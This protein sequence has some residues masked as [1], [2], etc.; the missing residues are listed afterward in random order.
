MSV[1][2]VHAEDLGA[3]KASCQSRPSGSCDGRTSLSPM[4]SACPS[5]ENPKLP[6]HGTGTSAHG[7]TALAKGSSGS[8]T[9]VGAARTKPLKKPQAK[10]RAG[11]KA[12]KKLERLVS[13]GFELEPA[14]AT[15]F[16]ALSARANYLS[17]D[18]LDI[19]FAGKEFCREFAIP[20]TNSF[21]KL[22]KWSDTCA[23]YRA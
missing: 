15:M 5:A 21:L 13:K 2:V 6:A 3:A 9:I 23:A 20:N 8:S 16:C 18:R 22:N 7:S 1:G 12:T 10:K 17:Q 19:S 4:P 11:A 14:E